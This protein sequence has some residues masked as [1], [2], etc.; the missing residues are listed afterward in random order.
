MPDCASAVRLHPKMPS[1][2]L[3]G[4]MHLRV[5]LS[6]PVPGRRRCRNNRR[7]YNAALLQQKTPLLKMRIDHRKDSPGQVMFFQQAAKFQ[8]CCIVISQNI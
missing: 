1:L 7:I 8:Q 4:L 3:P 6:I 2:T 5:S